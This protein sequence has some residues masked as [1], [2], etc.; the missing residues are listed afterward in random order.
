[1]AKGK[2]FLGLKHSS[3][4]LRL[5]DMM[6]LDHILQLTD[7]GHK[8]SKLH[9]KPRWT[10]HPPHGRGRA[11]HEPSSSHSWQIHL[12][13]SLNHKSRL[14][15][16]IALYKVL[17]PS[18]GCLPSVSSVTAITPPES[19]FRYEK[20]S[21]WPPLPPVLLQPAVPSRTD[22]ISCQGPPL[23]CTMK[24]HRRYETFE[25]YFCLLFI[26]ACL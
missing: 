3:K 5:L 16:T 24:Q 20:V 1:M 13:S 12:I 6:A 11:T 21:S 18:R 15:N 10:S 4:I 2:G 25:E 17:L 19:S 14:L 26:S 9:H 23:P 22:T 8:S 7:L